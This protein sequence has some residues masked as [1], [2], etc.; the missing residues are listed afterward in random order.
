MECSSEAVCC[1]SR[2]VCVCLEG[3]QGGRR[4]RLGRHEEY[5]A[6]GFAERQ[7]KF[8]RH[9]CPWRLGSA[10]VLPLVSL[11]QFVFQECCPF[12]LPQLPGAQP[13]AV[14]IKRRILKSYL[15]D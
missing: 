2:R 8:H 13:V 15:H 7:G 5:Q 14:S 11:H 3:V 12:P 10:T 9:S 6:V 1:Y 4:E